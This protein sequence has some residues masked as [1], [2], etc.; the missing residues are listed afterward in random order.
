MAQEG[1]IRVQSLDQSA[2]RGSIRAEL[3]VFPC[4]HGGLTLQLWILNPARYSSLGKAAAYTPH[5]EDSVGRVFGGEMPRSPCDLLRAPEPPQ[6]Q[7]GPTPGYLTKQESRGISAASWASC[8]SGAL[9]QDTCFS[10]GSFSV[11]EWAW[12]PCPELPCP[13]HSLS[14]T[15]SSSKP[16]LRW[17]EQEKEGC[18]A[19]E[20][21]YYTAGWSFIGSCCGWESGCSC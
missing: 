16:R 3:G 2:G 14:L 7:P 11:P 10:L 21:P 1:W 15:R 18:S 12:G 20:H 19:S 6:R 13:P 8:F 9:Y 4:R 5:L 17:R